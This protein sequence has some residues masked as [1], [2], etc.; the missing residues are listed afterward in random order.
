M[1]SDR[2][3]KVAIQGERGAFSHQA[4]LQALGLDIDV[5][6]RPTFDD[7]FSAV[8]DGK[9]DRALVPIENSLAGSIHENYDRLRSRPLHIV[10]ETQLR[11]R[12]C[13]IGRPGSSLASI[14]RVASH[15]VALAQCR[16]FFAKHPNIEPLPAYDTAGSVMDLLRADG[17]ATQG[18]IASKLAAELYGGKVLLEGLEDDPQNFTRF[19]ILAREPLAGGRASKTSLVF[20]LHNA[21][22]ALHRALGA[23]ASR[24][25]DLAKL[26]SRPLR[27]RPWEY[28]FYLDVLGDPA[29]DPVKA[30]LAELQALS[31]EYRVLGSYPNGIPGNGEKAR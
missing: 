13:L 7:L 11:I 4:A 31:T 3:M 29:R 25:V 18:A 5:V 30:A 8:T 1:T 15:P 9:A 16:D 26:E 14:R 6:P 2:A 22:G 10:A 23:F 28:S 21:P 24:D 19:L 27:G 12:H 20:T 17:P